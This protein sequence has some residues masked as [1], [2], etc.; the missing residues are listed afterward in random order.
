[1][2]KGTFLIICILCFIFITGCQETQDNNSTI[3]AIVGKWDIDSAERISTGEN[4]PLQ[5]L[6]GTGIEYGGVLEFYS[7]GTFSRW[8]G[9]T[10]GDKSSHEGTYHLSGDNIRLEYKNGIIDEVIYD[11]SDT[12][13]Y[14]NSALDAV[15]LYKRSA[16]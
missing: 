16:E 6:Y 10:D 12:L 14:Q 1:M 3:N 8:I 4:Y 13:K 5:Y 7:D 15:E 2:K 9:I 11:S